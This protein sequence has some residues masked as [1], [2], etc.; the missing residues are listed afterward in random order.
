MRLIAC[1]L[2]LGDMGSLR[3][4]GVDPLLGRDANLLADR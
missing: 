1:I 2:L 3:G 4:A